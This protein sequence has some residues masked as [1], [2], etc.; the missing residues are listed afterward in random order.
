MAELKI[1]VRA[2]T[3]AVEGD[4]K[5][6]AGDEDR[7]VHRTSELFIQLHNRKLLIGLQRLCGARNQRRIVVLHHLRDGRVDALGP[8]CL[9]GNEL[10]FERHR[11]RLH[12]PALKAVRKSPQY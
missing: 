9:E 12:V 8:V 1:A 6:S 5:R 2:T 4:K 3:S 7:E 10:I 11:F